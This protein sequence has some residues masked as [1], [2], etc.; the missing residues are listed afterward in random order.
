MKILI[1]YYELAYYNI[2]CFKELAKDNELFLIKYDVNKFEAPFNFQFDFPIKVFSSNR[3]KYD[4]L[5]EI[6][7]KIQ[8]DIIFCAGWVNKSYLKLCIAQKN[9]IKILGFD[10]IWNGGFIQK[11]KSSFLII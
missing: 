10:T 1:L 4:D 8:P 11:I 5:F 7:Q 9:P 3:M 6:S 2:P